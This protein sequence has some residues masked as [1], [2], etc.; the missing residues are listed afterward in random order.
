MHFCAFI[1]PS[2]MVVEEYI[3]LSAMCDNF[4]RESTILP[5]VK[6]PPAKPGKVGPLQ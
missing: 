3:L 6:V 2:A 1:S 4:P 5:T